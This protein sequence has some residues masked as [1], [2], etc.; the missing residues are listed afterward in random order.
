M[1]RRIKRLNN[2][3]IENARSFEIKLDRWHGIWAH[4]VLSRAKNARRQ[5]FS[6]WPCHAIVRWSLYKATPPVTRRLWVYDSINEEK[7][8]KGH[9]KIYWTQTIT[10][11]LLKW[12][13]SALLHRF[14][15]IWGVLRQAF[16][17]ELDSRRAHLVLYPLALEASKVPPVRANWQEPQSS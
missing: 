5:L 4:L 17:R 7:G 15:K 8:H 16:W 3:K 9:T 10:L 12:P 2:R 1:N 13:T 6:V 14:C 11:S